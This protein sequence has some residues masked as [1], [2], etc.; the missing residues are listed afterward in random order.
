[1]A[2]N[3]PKAEVDEQTPLLTKAVPIDLPQPITEDEEPRNLW[4]RYSDLIDR[5]PLITKGITATILFFMADLAAQWIEHLRG[6]VPNEDNGTIFYG[7]NVPRATRFAAFGLIGA[8]WSHYYFRWLDRCLPPSEE[9]WTL[10]TFTKVL[11][12]QFIQA[13]LLL[14]IMIGA[15]SIMKGQGFSGVAKDLKCHFKDT[16]IA[17]CMLPDHYLSELS[18]LVCFLGSQGS[19]GCRFP[20][21]TLLSLNHP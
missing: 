6:V 18:T 19:C 15:L 14:A 1:M 9:P 12:D 13:P 3:D 5:K 21:S 16:L 8:P 20:Q 11:I 2:A 7:V 17:N 4:Q 10:R